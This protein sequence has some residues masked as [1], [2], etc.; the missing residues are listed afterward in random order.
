MSDD[1]LLCIY[2]DSLSPQLRPKYFVAIEEGIYQTTSDD[3]LKKK[4]IGVK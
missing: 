2:A 1:K 4:K 3:R